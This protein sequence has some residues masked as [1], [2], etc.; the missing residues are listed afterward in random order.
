MSS[1]I[2]CGKLC[3]H[4][5]HAAIVEI[6]SSGIISVVFWITGVELQNENL[7]KHRLDINGIR[8]I[9]RASEKRIP[10]DSF[11]VCKSDAGI[12]DCLLRLYFLVS[13]R[14][15]AV[16]VMDSEMP[17]QQIFP[18][19]SAAVFPVKEKKK[20]GEDTVCHQI[21]SG[22]LS[23][24]EVGLATVQ[25]HSWSF[26]A[27]KNIKISLDTSKNFFTMKTIGG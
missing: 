15:T 23:A 2:T 16:S 7:P 8:Y 18:P 14:I 22:N 10:R 19:F 3:C 12:V 21:W 9:C 27:N 26:A 20:R 4:Q 17:N 5:N 13:G 24:I 25:G 1:N 6:T 11:T